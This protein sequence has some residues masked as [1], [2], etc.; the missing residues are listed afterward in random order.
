VEQLEGKLAVT[1]VRVDE[2]HSRAEE[3]GELAKVDKSGKFQFK[4]L[5]PGK[6]RLFAIEGFDEDLWGS[7]ELAAALRE[8]SVAVELTEDDR[9]Q[10][11]LPLITIDDFEKALRKIGM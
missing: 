6:H 8:K 3:L 10:V 9:K 7:P 2:D 4:K 11:T 1:V 5:T